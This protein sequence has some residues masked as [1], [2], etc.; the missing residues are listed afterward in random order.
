MGRNRIAR[1]VKVRCRGSPDPASAIFLSLSK[2]SCGSLI[3]PPVHTLIIPLQSARAPFAGLRPFGDL[4]GTPLQLVRFALK[5]L[6]E[7]QE[8]PIRVVAALCGNARSSSAHLGLPS[9]SSRDAADS[10]WSSHQTT[11]G[12]NGYRGDDTRAMLRDSDAQ[13]PDAEASTRS[14]LVMGPL[15]DE[16]YA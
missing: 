3:S 7:G 15:R 11:T 4:W 10:Y 9:Q 12:E 1:E 13:R 5:L 14:G 16:S 8:D 2:Q 6:G